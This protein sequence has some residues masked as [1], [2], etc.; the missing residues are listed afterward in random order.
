MTLA[1]LVDN[2]SGQGENAQTGTLPDDLSPD[3]P[4]PP[5]RASRLSRPPSSSLAAWS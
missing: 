3:A 5:C 1:L 4:R 2:R